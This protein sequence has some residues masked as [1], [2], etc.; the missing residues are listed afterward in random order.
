M[1][2]TI[3][4]AAYQQLVD[5][6]I[7]W[8]ERQPRTLE[9][10]HVIDIVRHSVGAYYDDKEVNTAKVF[11]DR[12]KQLPSHILEATAWAAGE[13]DGID[14]LRDQIATLGKNTETR[15]KEYRAKIEEL[16]TAKA[17]Y[18]DWWLNAMEN[19]G[20]AE[21]E[22]DDLRAQ[23]AQLTLE[24]DGCRDLIATLRSRVAERECDLTRIAEAQRPHCTTECIEGV[25]WAKGKSG[26]VY[27]PHSTEREAL[28]EVAEMGRSEQLKADAP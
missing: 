17:K 21:R 10:D 2:G 16:E 20:A 9:R 24:R 15:I 19:A 4:R 7:C 12:R 8:L 18:H 26:G 3:T 6:D 11:R 23:V 22:R 28:L 25:W 1:S 13:G 27:G 5:E 14:Q